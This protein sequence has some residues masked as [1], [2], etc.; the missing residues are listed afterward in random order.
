MLGWF[1]SFLGRQIPRT[2]L[3]EIS[4]NDDNPTLHPRSLP[5]PLLSPPL[6]FQDCPISK[7]ETEESQGFSTFLLTPPPEFK[8]NE[9]T[10]EFSEKL[11]DL[12][13][14]NAQS[15]ESDDA[16]LGA[17]K[18]PAL[19]DS[20]EIMSQKSVPDASSHDVYSLNPE[21]CAVYRESCMLNVKDK[22]R[23]FVIQKVDLPTNSAAR[24]K[25]TNPKDK[26]HSPH[27]A[28]KPHSSVRDFGKVSDSQSFE[29]DDAIPQNRNGNQNLLEG[30]LK[31]HGDRLSYIDSFL[32]LDVSR[33]SD[34][35]GIIP[36]GFE[37]PR[38]PP[39][40]SSCFD[41][42]ENSPEICTLTDQNISRCSPA[43]EFS[44]A[45]STPSGKRINALRSCTH[46]GVQ[47]VNETFNISINRGLTIS[48]LASDDSLSL[49]IPKNKR[50]NQ[51]KQKVFDKKESEIENPE[52][53]GFFTKAEVKPMKK[54]VKIKK[55]KEIDQEVLNEGY[56]QSEM[57]DIDAKMQIKVGSDQNAEDF[58]S[59]EIE[60]DGH[61][62]VTPPQRG[63]R[64]KREREKSKACNGKNKK[65]ESLEQN[66]KSHEEETF[67]TT[68]A[69]LNET[70]ERIFAGQNDKSAEARNKKKKEATPEIKA[71]KKS[72]KVNE[73]KV[74]GMKKLSDK[75]RDVQENEKDLSLEDTEK[76]VTGDTKNKTKATRK[77]TRTVEKESNA[78]KETSSEQ[79][80][81]EDKEKPTRKTKTKNVEKESKVESN[82]SEKRSR[83]AK[84]LQNEMK[85]KSKMA[86]IYTEAQTTA[87]KIEEKVPEKKIDIKNN[88]KA[89][90]P[91][92]TLKTAKSFSES[93]FDT[94][95]KSESQIDRKSGDAALH[96]NKESDAGTTA[97]EERESKMT[98]DHE[99]KQLAVKS[100][101]KRNVKSNVDREI[102]SRTKNTKTSKEDKGKESSKINELEMKNNVESEANI[103]IKIAQLQIL[104]EDINVEEKEPDFKDI[105][106]L[107]HLKK[108]RSS[109][110]ITSKIE[111][112]LS[113]KRVGTPE[114]G[115]QPGVQTDDDTNAQDDKTKLKTEDSK[116]NTTEIESQ[117][118][119]KR[120][121]RSKRTNVK[122]LEHTDEIG[123]VEIKEVL[124][125]IK[126]LKLDSKTKS[127]GKKV[128][129]KPLKGSKGN[130]LKNQNSNEATKD[131][132]NKS[133]K[134]KG[135]TR[136][137]K[138]TNIDFSDAKMDRE[139]QPIEKQEKEEAFKIKGVVKDK[140]VSK[141]KK[142]EG[143]KDY[144]KEVSSGTSVSVKPN[145]VRPGRHCK[146]SALNAISKML[147]Q[148]DC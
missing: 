69:K 62:D 56:N 21:G 73:M 106:N 28:N 132:N 123:T 35:A 64:T 92:R 1:L 18:I 9:K 127:S 50:R 36:K 60:S 146:T 22:R 42:S 45:E 54:E 94:Q 5:Q 15:I 23:T 59:N 114:R 112:K 128:D 51:P 40:T 104:D 80:K 137:R 55:N 93:L 11:E 53:D 142:N 7:P 4:S 134:K 116:T 20:N 103:H 79:T 13:I 121:T 81:S 10:T 97:D 129:A 107:A 125:K 138:A 44:K 57:I 17:N 135:N 88:E 65:E 14:R 70:N 61:Y 122:A 48:P 32:K 108:C 74:N 95:G 37:L 58:A 111:S 102:K 38:T 126:E 67:V 6:A 33:H 101:V 147:D 43:L 76:E 12:A 118:K 39:Q 16:I 100:R 115:M 139:E 31:E 29:D 89:P 49:F 124:T 66:T 19:Q 71:I 90:R 47:P 99:T 52:L 86:Q 145:L 136:G 130:S 105:E 117:T 3:K 24:L 78:E 87:L 148:S 72:K 133:E 120:E 141:K 83:E 119:K 27:L 91:K 63:T 2:P 77:K 26:I 143:E 25:R 34:A 113:S 144:D 82:K 75:K 68:N 96:L 140:K 30:R 109:A 98:K 85:D 131:E 41:Q 8:I 46:Q 84:S 110:Q